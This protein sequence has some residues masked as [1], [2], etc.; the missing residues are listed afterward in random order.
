MN[1]LQ[2]SIFVTNTSSLQLTPERAHRTS[3]CTR[4]FD[5]SLA[6]LLITML[7]YWDCVLWTECHTSAV[8]SKKGSGSALPATILSCTVNTQPVRVAASISSLLKSLPG[9]QES[10]NDNQW[11][12]ETY[13]HHETNG[14][15]PWSL[16]FMTGV[17]LLSKI[18][19]YSALCAY[20]TW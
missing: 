19:A 12:N 11:S 20:S 2:T 14:S 9:I 17:T 13:D 15:S 5:K 3:L 16:D 4:K 18:S 6:L 10:S 1:F 8:G 7:R